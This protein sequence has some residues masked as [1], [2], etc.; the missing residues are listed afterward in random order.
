M[1][2]L[3][4]QSLQ[5]QTTKK[6]TSDIL[7]DRLKVIDFLKKS[8]KLHPLDEL[9]RKLAIPTRRLGDIL[10]NRCEGYVAKQGRCYMYSRTERKVQ[11]VVEEKPKKGRP[12]SKSRAEFQLEELRRIAFEKLRSQ[13]N[14]TEARAWLM[15][16]QQYPDV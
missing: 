6:S 2:Q 1:N 9:C 16:Y 13:S 5:S 7:G 15:A 8:G 11:V 14:I 10:N 3:K 4:S 12:I